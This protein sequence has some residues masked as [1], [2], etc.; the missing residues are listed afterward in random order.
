[1]HL[2][3]PQARVQPAAARSQLRSESSLRP[4]FPQQHA[5]SQDA[6]AAGAALET[7]IAFLL[8]CLRS[9]STALLLCFA[10][11]GVLL[12]SRTKIIVAVL[13][14]DQRWVFEIHCCAR[15]SLC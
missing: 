8:F 3:S 2:P 11:L 9:C 13:K 7:C 6:R 12:G 4:R 14:G 5:A 15:Q 1:M 10:P